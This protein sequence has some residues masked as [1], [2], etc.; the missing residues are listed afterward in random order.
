MRNQ[1]QGRQTWLK[2]QVTKGRGLKRTFLRRKDNGN[3]EVLTVKFS[4]RFSALSQ[5]WLITSQVVPEMMA[6]GLKMKRT[7]RRG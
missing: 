5:W 6:G 7:G 3:T 4:Q 1:R 2:I